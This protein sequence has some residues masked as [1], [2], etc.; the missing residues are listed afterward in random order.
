MVW[1]QN[2][3]IQF[4]NP[5]FLGQGVS[6][7]GSDNSPYRPERRSH[8][9]HDRQAIPPLSIRHN[10]SELFAGQTCFPFRRRFFWNASQ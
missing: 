4:G 6:G 3:E 2:L 1:A 7:P 10:Q 5:Q 8:V 9:E